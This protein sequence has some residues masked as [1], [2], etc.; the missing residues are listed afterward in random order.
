MCTLYG[1]MGCFQTGGRKI[2]KGLPK[3]QHT[4]S[5]LL[6]FE[7][8]VNGG[9][10]IFQKSEFYK[11]IIFIFSEKTTISNWNNG[12]ISNAIKKI[13]NLRKF[14]EKKL[15]KQALNHD[16][17]YTNIFLHWNATKIS[18]FISQVNGRMKII[19]FENSEIWKLLRPPLIQ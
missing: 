9:L 5:K 18:L 13:K 15:N 19:D 6:Y 1:N 17:W 8:W 3:N 7:N 4:Q 12:L 16:V 14:S 11:S 2:R 10:R